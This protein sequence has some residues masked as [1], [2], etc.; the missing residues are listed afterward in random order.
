MDTF[1]GIQAYEVNLQLRVGNVG[2]GALRANMLR[3][4]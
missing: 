4:V 2:G 1:E 3:F